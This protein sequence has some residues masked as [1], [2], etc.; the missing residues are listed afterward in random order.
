LHA[1][2]TLA[3]RHPNRPAPRVGG[4]G[5]RPPRW[6]RLAVHASVACLV[7]TGAAWWLGHYAVFA[8][9]AA[10]APTGLEQ[11][12]LRLHGVA[13]YAFLL[14]LGSM[15][16]V[17]VVQAWRLDRHRLSGMLL[18]GTC[19]ALWISGLTLYYA[20]ESVHAAASAWHWICGLVLLPLLG[21]HVLW[22][23]RQRKA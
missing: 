19:T 15:L 16:T 1:A 21:W 3:R 8:A 2:A 7:G 12:S 5:L 10:E 18:G 6:Q 9:A 13:A 20:P 11:W 22:A 14:V 17:H 23:R 4:A